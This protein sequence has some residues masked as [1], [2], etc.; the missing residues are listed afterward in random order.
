MAN[1]THKLELITIMNG[2]NVKTLTQ[3]IIERQA[4]FPYA[5]GEFTRLL[6]QVGVAAKLVNKKVNKAGLV[7]VLG[8]AGNI[9]VQGEEQK[10]LDLLANW[11]F[12]QALK[13]SR[14]AAV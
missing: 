3:F 11:Q 10:K 4:D 6:Y 9:N 14:S 7:D 5:T 8:E 13:N 2:Y 12:V 1:F